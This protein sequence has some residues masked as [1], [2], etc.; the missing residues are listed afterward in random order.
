MN[1]QTSFLASI[2]FILIAFQSTNAQTDF[3]DTSAWTVGSGS[4]S[5][6]TRYGTD[7]INIR[8]QGTDPFNNQSIVWKALRNSSGAKGG[9]YTNNIAIDPTKTYRFSVWVKKTNSQDGI[10][11][12]AP[13]I[14]DSGSSNA[15]LNLN[16]SNAT[17]P[18]F[19]AGDTPE[20]NK[21][22]LYIAFIHGNG[23]SG[24]NLGGVYDPATG[25]MVLNG[26]D[27]QF[28]SAASIVRLRTYM[29]SGT[30]TSD[31]MITFGPSMY[32]VNGQEPTI[33]DLINGP[34]NTS[35]TQSPTAA[36]LTSTGHTDTTVSLSWS[37]ATDNVGVTGYKI[38][39]DNSLLTTLGTVTN[40]Q[41]SGL[42]ASTSYQFKVKALDAA[43]NES[44]DSNIISIT[45]DSD[46][47]S[48]G[49][50][51]NSVWSV[52]GATASYSDN[53]GIGT[54]DTGSYK[55]AVNGKIRTKE[56]KVEAANWPDY[57]FK[58]EYQLP[59]LEEI[60]K[61]IAEKG[62]LPNIPSA[63]EVENSGIELGEM[64]RLLLEKIEELTLY[65]IQQ[66]TRVSR[67]EKMVKEK[68]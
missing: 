54:T 56:V 38:Y 6:F 48:G 16:G 58:K 22:Y 51:G 18:L 24:S 25:Q 21:W 36:T 35:D 11:I 15:G 31:E 27:Y 19:E 29:Y 14:Y 59:S 17:N 40:H 26:T 39:W 12:F 65:I 8:E 53:V 41:V 42:T 45:T 28:S 50:T 47:D 46:S 67:I 1:K 62:H 64:N 57:V 44:G 3:I 20:L 61:H 52:N 68:L 55:L 10:I 33:Q 37:G 2:V 4:V 66:E 9:W 23:Y 13:N 60:Q 63:K 5:G 32:E 43:G 7:N 30:D 49:T 34:N